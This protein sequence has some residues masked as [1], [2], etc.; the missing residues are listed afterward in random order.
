MSGLAT[1]K[2]LNTWRLYVS[3][4][5]AVCRVLAAVP[6]N[7]H[8]RRDGRLWKHNATS[9]LLRS[10]HCEHSSH[11]NSYASMAVRL[12]NHWRAT[13]SPTMALG[14][15][16]PP[17]SEHIA[18]AA[19]ECLRRQRIAKRMLAREHREAP[20]S[21]SVQEASVTCSQVIS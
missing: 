19:Q 10:R 15:S 5:F 17:L 18:E 2:V 14:P 16:A 11:A 1:S 12:P 21:S 13:R 4:R 20:A 9:N 6:F 8:Q 3:T 7:T